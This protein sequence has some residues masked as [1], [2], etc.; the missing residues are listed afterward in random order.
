MM[1]MC[2]SAPLSRPFP[3]TT[4]KTRTPFTYRAATFTAM[5]ARPVTSRV[6]PRSPAVSTLRGR[7][8]A[9]SGG[10][11]LCALHRN[12]QG[13]PKQLS[14]TRRRHHTKHHPRFQSGPLLRRATVRSPTLF[15]KPFYT[16]RRGWWGSE[17]DCPLLSVY[18]A[19]VTK[20]RRLGASTP[21]VPCSVSS[22]ESQHE[23]VVLHGSN[24]SCRPAGRLNSKNLRIH[25]MHRTAT[26]F[27]APSPNHPNLAADLGQHQ[28]VVINAQPRKRRARVLT[29][30]PP[31][32]SQTRRPV[33]LPLQPTTAFHCAHPI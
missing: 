28:Q 20:V 31:I 18:G 12:L 7:Y 17:Y 5:H 23:I 24:A 29:T 2:F 10:D 27:T 19:W 3:P 11:P 6:K 33:Q 26:P 8:P 32:D 4:A 22:C 1:Y 14:S 25:D 9:P 21:Y 16:E 13:A 30:G 15:D